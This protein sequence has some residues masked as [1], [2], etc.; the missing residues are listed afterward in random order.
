MFLMY[1]CMYICGLHDVFIMYMYAC[2]V[3]K[4]KVCNKKIIIKLLYA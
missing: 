1:V 2:Y 4:T 3:I